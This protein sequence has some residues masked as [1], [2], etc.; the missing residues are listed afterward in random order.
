M[1]D[2]QRFTPFR[3]QLLHLVALLLASLILLVLPF[4]VYRPFERLEQ[5]IR[6][7]TSLI[8][9]LQAA[10]SREE[11][12]RLNG[13]ALKA[14]AHTQGAGAEDL[15]YLG[16]A[17]N[18]LLEEGELLPLGQVELRL[19]GSR[20][21]YDQR[22][23]ERAAEL[24][25]P[26]IAAD[27]ESFALLRDYKRLLQQTKL[28][29]SQSGF[30]FADIYVMIDSGKREG[31]FERNLL[32]LVDGLSWWEDSAFPGQ[33]YD[34]GDLPHWRESA[35]AGRSEFGHD[36]IH[37]PHRLFMPDFDEDAWGTWFSVWF[38]EKNGDFFNLI[39]LDFDAA[40]VKRMMALVL[41]LVLGVTLGAGL[42]AY[43]IAA[44][45]SRRLT[46]PIGA[47]IEGVKRVEQGDFSYRAPLLGHDELG[48]LTRCFNQ[49]VVGQQERANLQR[50]LEKLLS[51]ELADTAAHEGLLLGGRHADCTL[52]F[53]DFAGFSTLSRHLEPAATV[54]LLN[55]YFERLIPLIK[56]FGGFPDK[57]IGDAIVAIF[58]APIPFEDHAG[59]AV[60]CAIRMQQEMREINRERRLRGEP[61]FE[62]RIGLNSGQVIVGAIGC[63]MKLEYTS[64]GETTNLANRME[65]VS[66]IGHIAL[67]EATYRKAR[68]GQ[69][70][71]F[72]LDETPLMLE[73]KGYPEPVPV[74]RLFIDYLRVEKE[75]GEDPLNFYRYSHQSS[76]P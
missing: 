66:P 62:M 42:A 35:L 65:G 12:V 4:E 18:M 50:T 27:A 31:V 59:A 32:F 8:S 43:G 45:F 75:M 36:P 41:M 69:F 15:P 64:I 73:V 71:H 26:F 30:R 60:R 33:A 24:W 34:A 20:P 19:E 55:L 48:E 37:V 22:R 72:A 49:M 13:F 29:A 7:G 44:L 74:Y 54:A 52:L 10:F 2:I 38:T 28:R 56:Q 40:A 57:Y 39:T 51:K 67:A 58:G 53:T 68:P 76:S 16:L 23:L 1:S 70:A 11:L 14:Q 47:L 9:G 5:Q 17:F 21:D 25:R 6:Q 3:R 61:V 63:D 46:R